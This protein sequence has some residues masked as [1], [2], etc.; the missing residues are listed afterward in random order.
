MTLLAESLF[1]PL[2][3]YRICWWNEKK[4][5]CKAEPIIKSYMKIVASLLHGGKQAVDELEQTPWSNKTLDVLWLLSHQPYIHKR[6]NGNAAI[7]GKGERNQKRLRSTAL[8]HGTV[9]RCNDCK[10][11]IAKLQSS[12]TVQIALRDI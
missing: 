10:A 1:F 9:K 3:D 12:S 5:F 7:D 6:A 11:L 2:F 4:T 8:D